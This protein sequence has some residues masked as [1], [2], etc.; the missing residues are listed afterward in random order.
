MIVLLLLLLALS[1]AIPGHGKCKVFYYRKE[2]RD[3][4]PEE[5]KTFKEALL[6]LQQ[7]SDNNVSEWDHLTK[8]HLDNMHSVHGHARFFPWHRAY[9]LLLE[10]RL[11]EISPD[12]TIPYWDWTLDWEAPLNSPIFGEEYG[13]NISVGK[14]GDCRYP[15]SYRSPHCLG[16]IYDAATFPAYY[17]PDDV[18]TLIHQINEY[19]RF[20]SVIEIFPH[21][22][23]HETLG[24]DMATMAS[25]N[26][27]IFWLHHSMVDYVWWLWQ[28]LHPETSY[29]GDTTEILEPFKVT[30]ADMLDAGGLCYAYSAFSQN[31]ELIEPAKKHTKAI[32]SIAMW[33]SSDCWLRLNGISRRAYKDTRSMFDE[34]LTRK[35]P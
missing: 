23:V 31:P 7:T 2:F 33:K 18:R 14:D 35:K 21:A 15:R 10:R 19:D 28:K 6:S 3:M 1:L 20:R 17:A 11:Q 12:V 34:I 4:T 22:I 27:P 29:D 24:G 26:D 16:R 5:W 32:L 30:I 9:V 13:F 8:I 25:P